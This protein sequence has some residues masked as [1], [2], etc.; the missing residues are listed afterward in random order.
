[1][2][3]YSDDAFFEIHEDVALIK[4]HEAK[5]GF[6]PLFCD[7]YIS[8]EKFEFSIT[9]L[10]YNEDSRS[11]DLEDLYADLQNSWVKFSGSALYHKDQSYLQCVHDFFQ[12][13]VIK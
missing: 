11:A 7:E 6:S 10:A 9:F 5:Q 8:R 12:A 4:K 3:H 2:T 1:M 13:A